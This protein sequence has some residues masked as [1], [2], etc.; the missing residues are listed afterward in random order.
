MCLVFL[1]L[2]LPS[3]HLVSVVS[4]LKVAEFARELAGYPDQ[5]AV[6][7]VISGLR[8]GFRLGFHFSLK[9]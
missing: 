2:V 6:S 8:H 9:S 1:F 5:S 4:P 3:L 7:Y